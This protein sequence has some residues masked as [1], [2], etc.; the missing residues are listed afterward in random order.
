MNSGRGI[1]GTIALLGMGVIA[2]AAIY[3][4]N[5]GGTTGVTAT[6]GNVVNSTVTNMFK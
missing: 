6:T 2:V 1:G 5:K 4:L 3:Q